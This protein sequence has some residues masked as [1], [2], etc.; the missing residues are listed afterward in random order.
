MDQGVLIEKVNG[1]YLKPCFECGE[2]QS[3]LRLSYAK[4][5]L[6]LKKVC[7]KCSNRKTD[8]CHRGVYNGI[9]ITWFNKFKTSA[10]VRN[11]PFNISIED[12][13]NLYNNQN[14]KCSL[15][16]KEIGWSDFGQK[17]T[18]SLDRIDSNF[19]Y[20]LNNIQI[21]HKDI[22]FMKQSYSQDYFIEM[23]KFVAENNKGS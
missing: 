2:M 7:K 9:P 3:Y 15:S 10:D 14:G 16:G 6:E 8:N 21:V 22:N 17:H 19:G 18:A 11:I 20:E 12:V 5:S 4:Q 13:F 23:C 1:R